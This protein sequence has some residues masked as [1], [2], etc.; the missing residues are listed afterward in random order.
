MAEQGQQAVDQRTRRHLQAVDLHAVF[1]ASEQGGFHEAQGEAGF[2]HRGT[3]RDDDQVGRLETGSVLIERGQSA[4]QAG[5]LAAGVEVPV[6]LIDDSG[7]TVLQVDEFLRLQVLAEAEQPLLELLLQIRCGHFRLIGFAIAGEAELHEPPAMGALA[8][9]LRI[10]TDVGHRWHVPG[11][12]AEVSQPA[13][14][15]LVVEL[16][17]QAHHIEGDRGTGERLD[18]LEDQ[19][20]LLMEEVLGTELV[21]DQIPG[22]VVQQQAAQ[23]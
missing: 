1:G 19:P 20:V 22:V 14:F 12:L 16:L 13:G 21:G 8:H 6:D 15:G 4:G 11:Q 9:D 17:G 18:G 7:Q 2:A 10:G 5:G 23:D 3:R